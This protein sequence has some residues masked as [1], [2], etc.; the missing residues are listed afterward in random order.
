VSLKHRKQRFIAP[1]AFRTGTPASCPGWELRRA[2]RSGF[3]D[4]AR[5]V[6]PSASAYGQPRELDNW[7]IWIGAVP[8]LRDLV[9]MIFPTHL[10]V[11]QKS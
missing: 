1:T 4:S 7:I 9:L 6:L 5:I 3:R 2:A 10:L 8:I 11:A